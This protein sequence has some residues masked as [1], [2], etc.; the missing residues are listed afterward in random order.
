MEKSTGGKSSSQLGP[1]LD[2]DR[3]MGDEVMRTTEYSVLIEYY[4]HE[5]FSSPELSLSTVPYLRLN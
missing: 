3:R 5:N 2:Q 1:M 4:K